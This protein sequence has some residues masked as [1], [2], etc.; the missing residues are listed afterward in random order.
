[1]ENIRIWIRYAEVA[2]ELVRAVRGKLSQAQLNRKLGYET[3]QL[4]RWEAGKRSISW[5]NFEKLTRAC[6][7]D[8]RKVLKREFGYSGSADDSASLLRHFVGQSS[9]SG[10]AKTM[11]WRRR[12]P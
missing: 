5:V 12:I 10:F 11:R 7:V 2:R 4:Y 1:M 9:V 8:L 6:K 3:N